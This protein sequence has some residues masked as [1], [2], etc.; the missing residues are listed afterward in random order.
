MTAKIIDNKTIHVLDK[1]QF[2][3]FAIRNSGQ[4]FLDPPCEILEEKDKIIIKATGDKNSKWLWNYF[5]FDTNYNEIKKE[6]MQFKSLHKPIKA[7]AGIR[8]LRQPF[9]QTVISFII[10]ANN[11][12]K[13]FTKTLGQIDFE[14]LEK[15]SEEDFKKMGAGYRAPYLVKAILQQ[16]QMDVKLLSKLNNEE[17]R[18]ELQKITGVG[19][20]VCSCIMLF[21]SEFHRLDVAPVD[22]WI[23]K[24]IE[25]LGEKDAEVMFSHR[26]G[27]V[28]QQYIFYYL[29]NLRKELKKE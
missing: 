3:W 6:L 7:G 25:Q 2:D 9:V 4:I 26:Y 21:C 19:P 29:Q 15:Y 16:K 1:T 20:K 28:A 17:L 27:G 11:N 8:I 10:S 5:D 24:A 23:K 18:K 14:N 12:I 22:T 13:R